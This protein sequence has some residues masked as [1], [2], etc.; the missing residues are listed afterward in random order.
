[1]KG[2]AQLGDHGPAEKDWPG[3]LQEDAAYSK[4]TAFWVAERPP[5]TSR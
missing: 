4:R 3:R 2:S 5:D 1:M